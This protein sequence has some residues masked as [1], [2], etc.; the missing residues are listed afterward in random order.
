MVQLIHFVYMQDQIMEI[1]ATR[2]TPLVYPDLN[3]SR[4]INYGEVQH[5]LIK[6]LLSSP[7]STTYFS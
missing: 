5:V 1:Q 2:E 4:G 7:F 3:Y 6:M